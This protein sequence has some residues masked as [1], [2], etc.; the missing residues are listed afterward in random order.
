[1]SDAKPNITV[2]VDMT[3]PGQ[4]FA[5]CGLLEL[6]DRLWPGAEG[7]FEDSAFCISC[8]GRLDQLL[9]RFGDADIHSSLSPEDLRKL[10]SLLSKEKAA[11]TQ[12]QR[13]E[14]MRLQEM[15]R[16]ERLWITKP[17][18]VWL[19]WWRDN[20]GERTELKTWAAKQL[21][22]EMAGRMF[23]VV[24][25]EIG[26]WREPTCE[27]FF[28]SNDDSLPFNFDS[29]LCR[30]GN[31]RDAGFSADTLGL[32][33]SYRPLLELLAFVGFQ[34]FRPTAAGPGFSYCTWAIPLSPAVAATAASGSISLPLRKRY[35][36]ALFERTKYM[37]AFL[38]AVPYEG[39]V[40]NVQATASTNRPHSGSA[41]PIN[42]QV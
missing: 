26:R 5:C 23:S 38:P 21:V 24:R 33:S 11:L 13:E 19:D 18:N 10:A 35:A 37:K 27:V 30:T 6:A 12:A 9:A 8:A 15:W 31:A 2:N 41:T 17:F 28:E 4:F 20:L 42:K 3:N 1:M 25:R 16:M 32:K 7:W 36:F 39:S 34:R 40:T 22:A 14:K 29:D